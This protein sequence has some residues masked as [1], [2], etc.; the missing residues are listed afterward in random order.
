MY[1]QI[2]RLLSL[3]TDISKN[4]MTMCNILKSCYTF[5][6]NMPIF[7]TFLLTDKNGTV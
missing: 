2:P 1:P 3:I 5:Y 7:L 6:F 4:E